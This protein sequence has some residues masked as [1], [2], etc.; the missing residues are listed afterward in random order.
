M[1]KNYR[2]KAHK[3]GELQNKILLIIM[4]VFRYLLAA[5]FIF[6]GFVKAIDPLGTA[7]KI[8]DYLISFNPSFIA[9][10]PIALPIS[11]ALSGFE[12]IVGLNYLLNISPIILLNSTSDKTGLILSNE[13]GS[14]TLA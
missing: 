12:L 1:K 9:L 10:F 8:E 3:K 14:F 7:Y 6:S 4:H 11:I 5:T 13:T 2:H